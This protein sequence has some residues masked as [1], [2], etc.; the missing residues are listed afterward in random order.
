MSAFKI[1]TAFHIWMG[2]RDLGVFSEKDLLSFH[3]EVSALMGLQADFRGASVEQFLKVFCVAAG[4]SLFA[5]RGRTKT[6]PLNFRR[7]AA[8][9][10]ACEFCPGTALEVV[11]MKFNR[12]AALVTYSRQALA[13]RIANNDKERLEFLRL[14]QACVEMLATQPEESQNAKIVSL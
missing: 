5:L 8:I 13:E 14:R 11:G 7:Q 2:E 12:E 1:E 4:T 10:L 9:A 3:R 6:E